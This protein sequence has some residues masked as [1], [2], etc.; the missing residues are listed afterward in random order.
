MSPEQAYGQ[1]LDA[2]S[3]IWSFGCVLYEMLTGK[4][5]F[6]GRTVMDCLMA[7]VNREPDWNAVPDS[8]PG[9][10]RD[11]LHKCLRKS[12]EERI[13]RIQLARKEIEE[14]IRD[15]ARED[16]PGLLPTPSEKT[17]PILETY[18]SRTTTSPAAPPKPATRPAPSSREVWL[19]AFIVF[20]AAVAGGLAY[21][22][23]AQPTAEPA[24]LYD[25][26]AVLPFTSPGE[27]ARLAR[28]GDS[29][30][31]DI[32]G[33]LSK[34]PGLRMPSREEVQQA[35]AAIGPMP[36]REPLGQQLGVQTLLTGTL[37]QEKK[38]VLIRAELVDVRT[39]A[40]LWSNKYEGLTDPRVLSQFA[41]D[42]AENARQRLTG[43]RQ[44]DPGSSR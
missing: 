35:A 27:D 19:V 43:A 39:G 28:L 6:Q 38:A 16:G 5:P 42:I 37:S 24:P 4:P 30:L 32:A 10:I 26:V 17:D 14:S 44:P 25:S 11:L 8:T 23:W 21:L 13:H 31:A 12:P 29:L 36:G 15:V 41:E 22:R 7:I 20:L 33:R 40:I 18:P 9:R 3:D 1:P 2:R 34:I